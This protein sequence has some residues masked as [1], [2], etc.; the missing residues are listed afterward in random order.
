VLKA[1]YLQNKDFVEEEKSQ[2]FFAKIAG[3]IL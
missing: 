2:T 1:R 3:N